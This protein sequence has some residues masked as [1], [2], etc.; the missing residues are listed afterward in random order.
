MH[1]PG[2][3][4]AGMRRSRRNLM[5]IGAV[6]VSG[7]LGSMKTKPAGAQPHCAPGLQPLRTLALPAIPAS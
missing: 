3:Q 2:S 5:K 7:I 1:D 4:I 6:A